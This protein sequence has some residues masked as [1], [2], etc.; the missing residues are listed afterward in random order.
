MKL[1]EDHNEIENTGKDFNNKLT[2]DIP[3]LEKNILNLEDKIQILSSIIKDEHIIAYEQLLLRNKNIKNENEVLLLEQKTM[4]DNIWKS[5]IK[6]NKEIEEVILQEN[7]IQNH[8]F[9]HNQ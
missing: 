5:K 2:D 1:L 9:D 4:E 7:L 6:F 8:I 3:N